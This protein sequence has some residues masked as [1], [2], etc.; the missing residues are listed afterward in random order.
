MSYGEYPKPDEVDDELNDLLIAF[1]KAKY[2]GCNDFEAR[3]IKNK[4]RF[5]LNSKTRKG[6]DVCT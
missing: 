4:V 2:R 6:K 5:M 1:A 3:Q